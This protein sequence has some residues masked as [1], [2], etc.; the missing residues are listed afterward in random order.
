MINRNFFS[1]EK[2]RII[3]SDRFIPVRNPEN[4]QRE[5]MKFLLESGKKT[6]PSGPSLSQSRMNSTLIDTSCVHS[7]DQPSVSDLLIRD[8][9]HRSGQKLFTFSKT[10]KTQRLSRFYQ[11]GLSGKAWM[12]S[13]VESGCH[14]RLE[15]FAT[16]RK[17]GCGSYGCRFAEKVN[18]KSRI[19]AQELP[20]KVLDAPGMTDDFYLDVLDW[21]KDGTIA[22]GIEDKVFVYRFP[23]GTTREIVDLKKLNRE[24]NDIEVIQE[25]NQSRISCES[26]DQNN[27]HNTNDGQD[28]IPEFCLNT[29]VKDKDDNEQINT[30]N[31]EI[32]NSSQKDVLYLSFED[33]DFS[34]ESPCE[35]LSPMEP[36]T[37]PQKKRISFKVENFAEDFHTPQKKKDT[38]RFS[39]FEKEEER[40][41][42]KRLDSLDAIGKLNFDGLLDE[43]QEKTIQIQK[44]L[45][46]EDH[47]DNL[48]EEAIPDFNLESD[49]EQDIDEESSEECSI[50][51]LSIRE[52]NSNSNSNSNSIE[53]EKSEFG[54]NFELNNPF[55]RNPVNQGGDPNLLLLEEEPE[56]L[57]SPVSSS[58]NAFLMSQVNTIVDQNFLE[59]PEPVINQNPLINQHE[60]A[61]RISNLHVP[62]LSSRESMLQRSN[63]VIGIKFNS[64][65][66]LLCVIDAKGFLYII[67]INTEKVMFKKY[68]QKKVCSINWSGESVLAV[69]DSEGR[70][71]LFDIS[72]NP[73]NP[74]LSIKMHES[75]I[76]KI[77]FSQNGSYL[78]TSGADKQILALD[79]GRLRHHFYSLRGS[80]LQNLPEI[81]SLSES[82]I[83]SLTSLPSVSKALIFHPLNPRYLV[84]GGGVDD[85]KI[86]LFDIVSKKLLIKI[87]AGSQVCSLGFDSVGKTL[88]SSHGF[89][90]NVIKLWDLNLLTKRLVLVKMLTGHAERV[91]HLAMSPCGKYI[92]S[93]SG[94]ETLRIWECFNQK[95]NPKKRVIGNNFMKRGISRM[96]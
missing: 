74:L 32:I 15:A 13:G 91:L 58:P 25:D 87:S 26:I 37:P 17:V 90:E 82:D 77:A 34:S 14:C 93:G 66:K 59:S 47:D 40:N 24:L 10:P 33:S 36:T 11:Q 5:T 72:R 20:L 45:F 78:A 84:V 56:Q 2:S 65:G 79:L 53:T 29:P 64:S 23:E 48:R 42:R 19:N 76:L 1:S 86:R 27:N 28:L 43:P 54:D 63:Q 31:S 44:R 21:A 73:E 70:L 60:I 22:L 8:C 39:I 41:Q 57:R 61:N 71:R 67:E 62:R 94:D 4:S 83:I 30:R 16:A 88:I 52:E 68:F 96:R 51:S 95:I 80:F 89:S 12:P 55:L 50:F 6:S 7:N 81:S 18:Q 46:Q 75:E 3:V 92:V 35:Q 49:D 38:R 9:L 69:G 85:Q